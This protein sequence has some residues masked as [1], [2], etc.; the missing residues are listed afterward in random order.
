MN[1]DQLL[2]LPIKAKLTGG[3]VVE[4]SYFNSLGE[5]IHSNDHRGFLAVP[6]QEHKDLLDGYFL[7]LGRRFDI[8]VNSSV[9]YIYRDLTCSK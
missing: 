5:Y 9:H 1:I 8:L 3:K 2:A 6:S 4:K 7:V